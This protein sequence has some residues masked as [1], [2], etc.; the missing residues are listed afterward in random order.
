MKI[1]IRIGNVMDSLQSQLLEV[2][3]HS[4]FFRF[5]LRYVAEELTYG[6]HPAMSLNANLWGSVVSLG[7]TVSRGA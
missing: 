7:P 5:A 6:Q 2:M 3:L 1:R 4:S